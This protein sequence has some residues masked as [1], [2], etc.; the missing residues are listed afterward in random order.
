MRATK[1]LAFD[2]TMQIGAVASWDRNA[3]RA[4][5]ARS[6]CAVIDT[7]SSPGP[8]VAIAAIA[9]Q[10]HEAR[11][12]ALAA[13]PAWRSAA[14]KRVGLC[15]ALPGEAPRWSRRRLGEDRQG[16]GRTAVTCWPGRREAGPP[17]RGRTPFVPP[18]M[19]ECFHVML[20]PRDGV[21]ARY[22]SRRPGSPS[23]GAHGANS[24]SAGSK[25]PL[26]VSWNSTN[27]RV[28]STVWNAGS[29]EPIEEGLPR[30]G[31]APCG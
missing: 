30:C 14:S 12:L 15:S 13:P 27:G 8:R 28:T 10:E 22:S 23:A 24:V 7:A 20:Q 6:W 3:A 17:V 16:C 31:R 29:I 19:I 1:E 26:V 2:V 9:L 5:R 21:S 18:M 11:Q 25:G 4:L